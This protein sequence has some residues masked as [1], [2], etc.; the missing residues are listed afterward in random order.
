[1]PESE[2]SLGMEVEEQGFCALN[3]E[4]LCLK[5]PD[6]D[7]HMD[8]IV[9]SVFVIKFLIWVI[10]LVLSGCLTNSHLFPLHHSL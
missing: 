1:M 4:K 6:R 2:V 7:S 10:I 5:T 3:L 8:R 9:S